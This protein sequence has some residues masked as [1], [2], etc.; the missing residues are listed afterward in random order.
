MV[1]TM[2]EVLQIWLPTDKKT[3]T[4]DT[5]NAAAVLLQVWS[6]PRN[7]NFGFGKYSPKNYK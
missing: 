4:V 6:L 2:L 5:L 7:K 1:R 3:G